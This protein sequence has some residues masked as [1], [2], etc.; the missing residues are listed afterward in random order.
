MKV[1]ERNIS[2]KHN[3]FKKP[4][5]QEAHQLDIYKHDRGVEL[6]SVE[7]KSSLVDR[8]GLEPANFGFQVQRPNHSATLPRAIAVLI[9]SLIHTLTSIHHSFYSYTSR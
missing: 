1:K 9:N 2:N 3:R 8:A 4:N 7:N 6:G 5:W